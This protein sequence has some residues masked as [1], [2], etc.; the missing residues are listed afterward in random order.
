VQPDTVV[1]NDCNSVRH[2]TQMLT[3]VQQT[4]KVVVLMSSA[5]TMWAASYVL[6]YLD[7]PVMDTPGH[8]NIYYK[9]TT[10]RSEF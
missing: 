5:I 9:T 3:S 10:A 4:T 2:V 8:V 7:T 6:V 1:K